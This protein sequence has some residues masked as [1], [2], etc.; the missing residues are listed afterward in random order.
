MFCS[1]GISW[2]QLRAL[3]QSITAAKCW[4]YAA[5]RLPPTAR[6]LKTP[7]SPPPARLSDMSIWSCRAEFPRSH[8]CTLSHRGNTHTYI[9]PRLSQYSIKPSSTLLQPSNLHLSLSQYYPAPWG[10]FSRHA[11]NRIF[12]DLC[13]YFTQAGQDLHFPLHYQS[14]FC[15]TRTLQVIDILL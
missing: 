3:K 11:H 1:H 6:S 5:R 13:N 15:H 7:W 2:R 10:L 4:V 9:S 8:S 12:L 14:G